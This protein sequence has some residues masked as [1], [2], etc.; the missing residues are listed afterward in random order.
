VSDET[1]EIEALHELRDEIY[2]ACMRQTPSVYL[3]ALAQV[4]ATLLLMR[5]STVLEAR[6]GLTEFRSLAKRQMDELL[7]VDAI[8]QR[9]HGDDARG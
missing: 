7:E 3:A 6:N 1:D 9:L 4:L 8:R 2:E 5:A